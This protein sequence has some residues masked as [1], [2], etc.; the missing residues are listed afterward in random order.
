[1]FSSKNIFNTLYESVVRFGP[2][3][4]QTGGSRSG[5]PPST[6]NSVAGS[7][8]YIPNS[9]Q[10]T[11]SYGIA[12][13][14]GGDK[15]GND[16]QSSKSLDTSEVTKRLENEI[17]W[18]MSEFDRAHDFQNGVISEELFFEELPSVDNMAP[19]RS[20]VSGASRNG[21]RV[22]SMRQE[23]E[24][25]LIQFRSEE[26][27]E[28]EEDAYEGADSS[29]GGGGGHQHNPTSQVVTMN[30]DQYHA[31][32]NELRAARREK[33]QRERETQEATQPKGPTRARKVA[34][35]P[36]SRPSS[37][38]SSAPSGADPLVDI[39]QKIADGF[40]K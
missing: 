25:D 17:N 30:A 16:K 9:G 34:R 18:N 14:N 26:E 36:Q 35:V 10:I 6:A 4:G 21:F 29:G 27:N 2:N 3:S 5:S 32:V 33:S 12:P 15:R 22:S 31:M 7:E 20:M 1:M 13:T 24:E 38:P 19:P 8:R 39:L 40:D 11:G 28:E 37:G 23:S